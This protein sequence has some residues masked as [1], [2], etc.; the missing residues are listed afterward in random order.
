MRARFSHLV[1]GATCI[2][3][4]LTGADTASA[5]VG[6]CTEPVTFGTTISATG[7]FSVNA[8]RWVKMTEIFAEEVNKRGGIKLAGCDGK[9]VPLKFVI[10][11]DQSTPATAVSLHEKLVTVDQVDVLV[12]PDWTPIGFPVSPIPDKHKIPIVMANVSALQSSSAA[13]STSSARRRRACTCGRIATSTSSPSSRTRRSRSSLRSRQPVHQGRR[14]LRGKEGRGSRHEG[15]RQGD[16]SRRHQGLQLHRAAHEGSEPRH[17][18][19]LVVRRPGASAHPADA[20]TAGD[21]EKRHTRCGTPA[22]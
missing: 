5:K 15:A 18:L 6:S 3:V 17:R 13:S 2:A 10:Y 16:I 19:H 8:D 1:F 9:S 14:R 4:A 7:P 12:G 20:P 21:R 22:R 11:D